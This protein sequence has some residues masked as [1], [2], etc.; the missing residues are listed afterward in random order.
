MF[1][2]MLSASHLGDEDPAIGD[3]NPRGDAL[4]PVHHQAK[5]SLGASTSLYID[6]IYIYIDLYIYRS[7]YV[8]ISIHLYIYSTRTLA[9]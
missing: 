1:F 3:F 5:H 8:Y 4:H 2:I 6:G 7:I 9:L